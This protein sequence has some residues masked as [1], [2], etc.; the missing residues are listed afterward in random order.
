MAEENIGGFLGAIEK[1]KSGLKDEGLVGAF[2]NLTQ[3][4]KDINNGLLSA[5]IIKSQLQLIILLFPVLLI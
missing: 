1:L 3:G 5:S 4:I 2:D